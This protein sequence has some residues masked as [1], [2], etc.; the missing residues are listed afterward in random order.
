MEVVFKPVSDVI[1][2]EYAYILPTKVGEQP[3]LLIDPLRPMGK[4][5]KSLHAFAKQIPLN[6]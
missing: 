4:V 5:L 1:G 6:T 3:G 2:S